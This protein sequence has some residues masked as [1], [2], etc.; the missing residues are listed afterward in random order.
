M[1]K[2]K[3]PD[4]APLSAVDAWIGEWSRVPADWRS[5]CYRLDLAPAK[6]VF[7][8]NARYLASSKDYD[9]TPAGPARLGQELAWWVFTCWAEGHRKIE[10]SMLAWWRRAIEALVRGTT[11][12]SIADL[13]PAVVIRQAILLVERRHGRLPSPGNQRNLATLAEHV[14]LMVSTR[15]GV[16]PWWSHDIWD[17]RVDP[18]IPRREHEPHRD[19]PLNLSVIEPAW[20]REG[21]RF[22]LRTALTHQMLTWTTAVTRA[23]TVGGHLGRYTQLHG[24]NDPLAGDDASEVRAFFLD[25][26]GHLRSPAATS[27]R[28]QLGEAHIAAI[29]SHVQSFYSFIHDH[30]GETAAATGQPRWAEIGVAH[31]RLWAPAHRRR[32]RGKTRELSWIAASD[33]RRM[34]AYIEVLGAS[35][36]EC[37]T[38]ASDD[39]SIA[40]LHGLGDP[41]AMRAWL[42]QAMTGWRASEILMLDFDPLTAIGSIEPDPTDDGQFVARLRYQ[43]TK[44]DGVDPTILVEQAIVNII[45]EQQQWHR[46]THPACT[47]RYLFAGLRHNHRGDQPRSYTSYKDALTRLDALHGLTDS[48]GHQLRFTQTH[49]LRHTRATE[50][51]ND[52]VPFHVV[53]RYLGHKSPE[54]TARYAATLAATAEAEFLKHKKIGA[55]GATVDISPRDIYEL[56]QLSKRTDRVLPNGVCLLPPVKTCDKGNACLSCGHFA[57]DRTHLDE[58]TQQR[59]DTIA[60]LEQRRRDYTNRTG[61]PLDDNNIWITGRRH[62]IASLDAIIATLTN[63]D[64]DPTR[65]ATRP[66]TDHRQPLLQIQ[67]RG[68][69]H[70]LLNHTNT[71]PDNPPMR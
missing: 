62:E 68:A 54:M 31:T 14:H 8:R 19:R 9:F 56:T 29:Q 3:R 12:T 7:T 63:P 48:A 33:L 58:L 41:Q 42:L 2:A 65:A 37:V 49:R 52:G 23:K 20:L 60:L 45:T 44:I 38:V 4:P 6:E 34:L 17:L 50:L 61:R 21:L 66:G 26:L 22:W 13:G 69:H 35:T 47:P 43:Q 18:A 11:I 36:D 67:T 71:P 27:G 16:R 46:D 70:S 53:Q 15:C 57:T 51:L 1:S 32:R 40:L 5:P 28:T 10:P 24:L 55:H 59:S 39:G 30:V 64:T 25:F